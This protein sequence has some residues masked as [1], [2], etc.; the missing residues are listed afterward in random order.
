MAASDRELKAVAA[1]FGFARRLIRAEICVRIE[2][3]D[4]ET[5][6]FTGDEPGVPWWVPGEL[7]PPPGSRLP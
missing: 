3:A 2:C 5:R 4:G 1:I 7:P 6:S